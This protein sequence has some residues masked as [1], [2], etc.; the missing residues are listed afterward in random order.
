MGIFTGKYPI[1]LRMR[2]QWVYWKHGL[3]AYGLWPMALIMALIII[4]FL[5]KSGYKEI[6]D[7]IYL[8]YYC[9]IIIVVKNYNVTHPDSSELINVIMKITI[10]TNMTLS[11]KSY[12][13]NK[14]STWRWLFLVS[15]R[16][17]EIE[18]NSNQHLDRCGYVTFYFHVLKVLRKAIHSTSLQYAY[19]LY[20]LYVVVF[21]LEASN[22]PLVVRRYQSLSWWPSIYWE[23][24]PVSRNNCPHPQHFLILLFSCNEKWLVWLD[25]SWFFWERCALLVAKHLRDILT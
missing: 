8:N 24:L 7:L 6:L 2:E 25:Y 14:Q 16:E 1:I 10:N 13:N 18:L 22:I 11:C 5:V 23:S 9:Y 3:M 4:I 17:V 15:I 21:V 12:Q 20:V 19:F